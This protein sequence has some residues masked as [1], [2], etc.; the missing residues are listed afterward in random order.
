LLTELLTDRPPYDSLDPTG[1]YQLV[2]HTDR[3]SPARRGVDVGPWQAIIERAVSLKPAQRFPDVASFAAALEQ[4]LDGA[5]MA[6]D[7]RQTSH[8]H[9]ESTI[10][11]RP[12][13]SELL[14]STETESNTF[15]VFSSERG[16]V[17]RSLFAGWRSRRTISRIA[18]V[19]AVA[20]TAAY[21]MAHRT[22]EGRKDVAI[23]VE[24][25]ANVVPE[26]R[27]AATL[28]APA[29]GG[30]LAISDQ[31]REHPD[32][33]SS[34]SLSPSQKPNSKSRLTHRPNAAPLE[35]AAP[36]PPT[37]PAR[38]SPLPAYVVE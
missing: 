26:P 2:F 5:S 19:T 32:L 14:R 34:A 30:A 10:P 31:A 24:R 33:P 25:P 18:A 15:S 3:P 28:E 35:P 6:F 37:A 8:D 20:A 12:S 4:S 36:T 21:F 9:E 16:P 11:Q 13:M 1:L 17:Q 38:T 7:A 22:A 27:P 23:A 29:A